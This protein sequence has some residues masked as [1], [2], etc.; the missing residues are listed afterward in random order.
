MLPSSYC[1]FMDG[2]EFFEISEFGG[3]LRS[4]EEVRGLEEMML[5]KV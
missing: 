1:K 5:V 4:E 2:S 3:G